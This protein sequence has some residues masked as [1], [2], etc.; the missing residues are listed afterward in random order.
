M[1]IIS[2]NL[3][4]LNLKTTL[5]TVLGKLAGRSFKEAVAAKPS[6]QKPAIT[7]KCTGMR[8]RRRVEFEK[9]DS[10]DA[11]KE[12]FCEQRV[13]RV[14]DTPSPIHFWGHH[15]TWDGVVDEI[16]CLDNRIEVFTEW[17]ENVMDRVYYRLETKGGRQLWLYRTA[18]GDYLQGVLE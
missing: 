12:S 4:S 8:T 15:V 14:L 2:L 1:E 13:L 7:F 10:S 11:K 18:E 3:R 9:A 17:W 5:K 6:Q 16:L